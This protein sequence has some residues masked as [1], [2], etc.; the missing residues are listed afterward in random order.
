M[1]GKPLNLAFVC[2]PNMGGSGI[3]ATELAK[4][5]ANRGHH[6]HLVAGNKPFA[7]CEDIPTLHFHKVTVNESPVFE[8]SPHSLSLAGTLAQV[9][10]QHKIDVVHAHY[11]IPYGVSA[12]L[13]YNSCAIKPKLM[14]TLHG[15]DIS[16]LSDDPALNLMINQVLKLS[17]VVTCV[18]EELAKQT[19]EIYPSAT[20]PLVIPNFV[21]VPVF[22]NIS[23]DSLRQELGLQLDKSY[24]VHVSN[25]RR[26]KRIPDMIQLLTEPAITQDVHLLLVGD[27][28]E[29]AFCERLVTELGLSKQVSFIGKSNTAWKWLAAAN[30]NLQLSNYESFGLTL[31]EAM[32][33]GTPSIVTRTG[34]MVQVLG[35]TG[36]SVEIGDF[37]TAAKIAKQWLSLDKEALKQQGLACIKR[38]NDCYSL[39]VVAAQY[40]ALYRRLL[41]S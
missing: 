33:Y 13:A 20:K 26:I 40:V 36:A 5:L 4:G 39:E 38:A 21:T 2:N 3:L 11:A 6:I 18:S 12:L 22:K 10:D 23:R 1:D 37:K 31:I 34:G 7:W 8:S 32:A 14:T 24:L 17:D 27:G 9:I 41:D 35:D 30:I 25:F 29:R 19:K 16:T 15:T 28:P